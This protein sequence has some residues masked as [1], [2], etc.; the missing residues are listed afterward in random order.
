MARINAIQNA[1]DL[2][3]EI[4]RLQGLGVGALFDFGSTQDEKNSSQVIGGADQG[5]LGCRTAIITQDGRKIETDCKQLR[6]ARR[7]RCSCLPATIRQGCRRGRNR[8]MEMETT[9]AEASLTR[10]E[11]R[12]PGKN[13][14]PMPLAEM[15][16][17]TPDWSWENYLQEV[18]SP[19]VESGDVSSAGIL[20]SNEPGADRR[21]PAR[22]EDLSALASAS[23]GGA[24]SVRAI[25]E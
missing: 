2:Q 21:F 17:L 22:L 7:A 24:R 12:D 10:V 20:Q 15:Q 5:G 3:A 9:L 19:V 16:A 8:S 23:C 6:A 14:H 13:Y 1:Q 18:G 25:C 11:L 4:A